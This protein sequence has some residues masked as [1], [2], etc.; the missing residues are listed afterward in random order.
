ML[1]KGELFYAELCVHKFLFKLNYAFLFLFWINNKSL[2][3]RDL[4]Q[5]Y[6]DKS[7]RRK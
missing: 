7:F 6:T 5:I 2:L 3:Q 1:K 4:H